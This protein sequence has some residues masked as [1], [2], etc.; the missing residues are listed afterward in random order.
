M[1]HL[2]TLTKQVHEEAAFQ[3]DVQ[4]ELSSRLDVLSE[5]AGG[6]GQGRAG[7]AK[8]RERRLEPQVQAEQVPQSTFPVPSTPPKS[9]L[10]CGARVAVSQQKTYRKKKEA[11]IG[12]KQDTIVVN[13][14]DEDEKAA[15]PNKPHG[16]AGQPQAD[17]PSAGLQSAP[18]DPLT[19]T[20]PWRRIGPSSGGASSSSWTAFLSSVSRRPE[21]L[22]EAKHLPR[23]KSSI[24]SVRPGPSAPTLPP[25]APTSAGGG[26]QRGGAR[27]PEP[28]LF[29]ARQA[30]VGP[31][32]FHTRSSIAK[33]EVLQV[34]GK[35]L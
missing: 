25:R 22:P 32:R 6:L 1:K 28:E 8:K 31:F 35:P 33:E 12:S 4:R 11:S 3:R 20:D 16:A 30:V 23:S 10:P 19:E 34:I 13:D 14:E 17:A 27:E 9:F 21:G 7:P 29:I 26:D 18:A 5:S 24:A 2:S 15:A